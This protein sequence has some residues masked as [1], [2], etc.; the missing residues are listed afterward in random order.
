MGEDSSKWAHLPFR[1][2][3]AVVDVIKDLQLCI[4]VAERLCSGLYV[5]AGRNGILI[6]V[7]AS[8]TS[9]T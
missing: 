3:R 9:T 8:I 4:T 6:A 7:A 5:T 1:R 2:I